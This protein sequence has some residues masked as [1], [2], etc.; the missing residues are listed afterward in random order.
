LFEKLS[1]LIGKLQAPLNFKILQKNNRVINIF[2]DNQIDCI[3]ILIKVRHNIEGSFMRMLSD[4]AVASFSGSPTAFP[5]KE[6]L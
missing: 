3:F 2:I 6:A 4:N 5:I 1:K